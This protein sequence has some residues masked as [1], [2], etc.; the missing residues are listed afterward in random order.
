VTRGGYRLIYTETPTD[1]FRS[2]EARR[3][4]A[5]LT[6]SLGLSVNKDGDL[7]AVQWEGPAFRAGLTDGTKIIAIN[8]LGFDTDRLKEAVSLAKGKGPA[9]NLIVKQGEHYRSVDID[10]HDGLR[11]PRF[12]RVPGTE[13]RLDAILAPRKN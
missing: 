8:G 12:E 6:Y 11:Y 13:A 4:G 3:K 1:Y 7:V 9:V 10:Y 2:S 5:D